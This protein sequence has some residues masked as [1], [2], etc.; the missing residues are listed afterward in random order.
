MHLALGRLSV[1]SP[2][3]HKWIVPFQLLIPGWMGLYTFQDPVGLSSELSCEAGS[4]SRSCNPHRCFPSEALRLYLPA[5]ML[6][7]TICLAPQL[8]LLVYRHKNVG[9]PGP[10]AATSPALVLW[11]LPCCESSALRL[12]ISAPPTGLDECF[13]FNSLFVGLPYS[14]IFWRFWLFFVFAFVVVLR[15][16]V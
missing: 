6:G 2:D 15:L 8:F 11:P 9:P 4:F 1:T 10:P 7:C 16:V 14:L 13:F 3:T 12:P 5:R